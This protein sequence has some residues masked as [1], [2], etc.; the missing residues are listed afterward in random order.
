MEIFDRAKKRKYRDSYDTPPDAKKTAEDDGWQ[1]VSQKIG[2]AMIALVFLSSIAGN[3]YQHLQQQQLSSS[4]RTAKEMLFRAEEKAADLDDQVGL[5]GV[6]IDQFLVSDSILRASNN[7][8]SQEHNEL[9]KDYKKLVE[10]NFRL[11]IALNVTEIE[12]ATLTAAN[13]LLRFANNNNVHPQRRPSP[14]SEPR[15]H[16]SPSVVPP[17]AHFNE[18]PGGNPQGESVLAGQILPGGKDHDASYIKPPDRT[19]PSLPWWARFSLPQVFFLS[20]TIACIPVFF[21]AMWKMKR[22]QRNWF[23]PGRHKPLGT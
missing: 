20:C 9:L 11:A 18:A 10:N 4:A 17:S 12:N 2:D 21:H 16:S 14:R 23:R 5:L 22:H 19:A 7:Q 3:G 1:K 13:H 15:R 6:R 8:L